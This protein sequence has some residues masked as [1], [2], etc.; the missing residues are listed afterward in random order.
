MPSINTA[1]NLIDRMT[2]PIQHIISAVNSLITA[3]ERAGTSVDGAFD[4]NVFDDTRRSLDLASREMQEVVAY[5]EQARNAQENYNRSVNGG[6]SGTNKLLD[7]VKS[8]AGAYIGM[9]GIQKFVNMSD[10]Y[11]QTR[12]RLN[13]TVDDGGSV[14]ELESKIR[15][16][17][18]R[19]RASYSATA[20]VV[21]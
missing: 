9:Q 1:I 4:V 18:N 13:L 16:S 21:A 8:L 20:D 6:V 19:A 17:A 3:T 11:V 2:G 5:T 7:T 12:A 15:A 14:D 10:T